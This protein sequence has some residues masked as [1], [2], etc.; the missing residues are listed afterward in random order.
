MSDAQ[1][2]APLNTTESSQTR[3]N[4]LLLQCNETEIGKRF[5]L[6]KPV[7]VVGRSSAVDIRV[8]DPSVSR[9][10]AMISQ[11][12]DHYELEDRESSSGTFVNGERISGRY[13][14][15]DGDVISLGS[16]QLRFL[17]APSNLTPSWRPLTSTR[18]MN[19][20]GLAKREVMWERL[21]ELVRA[22]L[23]QD[24][25]LTLI[26][27]CIDGFEDVHQKFGKEQAQKLYRESARLVTRAVRSDDPIG[28]IGDEHFSIVLAGVARE[29]AAELGERIRV[30]FEEHEFTLQ[31]GNETRSHRQTV[32]LGVAQFTARLLNAKNL[33]HAAHERMVI[34]Q[35]NGGNRLTV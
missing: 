2:T 29:R 19:E 27:F 24:I 1:P 6:D 34:S 4:A 28:R 5:F 16:I 21:N 9:H 3:V 7:K 20:G 33:L 13:R 30:L 25:D 32:S 17:L 31:K 18:A 10:H 26:T 22:H 23:G 11:H 35:K 12:A 14:L 15:Q 8:E